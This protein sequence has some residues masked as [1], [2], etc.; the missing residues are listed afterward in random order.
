MP[1]ADDAAG[2]R[3]TPR[4][5]RRRHRPLRPV[6][7]TAR[8]AARR[9][10]ATP[11]VPTRAAAPHSPHH[12]ARADAT[13]VAG[14]EPAA[15]TPKRGDVAQAAPRCSLDTIRFTTWN[16]RALLTSAPDLAARRWRRIE[17][18]LRHTDALLVQETHGDEDSLQLLSN[19]R[20]QTHF[21]LHSAGPTS[22]AG[23]LV[24]LLAKSTFREVSALQV[25]QRGRVAIAYCV[26]HSGQAIAVGNIHN[27]DIDAGTVATL[28]K[29]IVQAAA[30]GDVPWI[31][32]GDWNFPEA[33]MPTLRTY[34][35]GCSV[36]ARWA[37]ASRSWRRI[38]KNLV[39]VSHECSTRFSSTLTPRGP[40]LVH[41][42]LDRMYVLMPN[43]DLVQHR[44]VYDV[45]QPALPGSPQGEL[46]DHVPVKLTISR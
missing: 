21:Y 20:S 15:T 1:N 33:G 41:S 4:R 22:D 10:R 46:S 34:S 8:P 44:F 19:R 14:A 28:D 13:P 23:G 2:N 38:L 25:L 16:S 40:V 7:A 30:R 9:A 24:F 39:A 36:P 18:L 26:L 43:A 3:P 12:H 27:Y 5:R 32:A 29:L 42:S 31:L 6:A 11:T 45:M 35:S 17:A 37:S